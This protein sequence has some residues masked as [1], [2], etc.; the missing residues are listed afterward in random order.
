MEKWYST[1]GY[2]CRRIVGLNKGKKEV[3]MCCHY[4]V[5]TCALS[6]F[7]VLSGDETFAYQMYDKN[8]IV[9]ECV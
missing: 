5:I 1:K 9:V 3:F 4:D 6:V 8:V 7:E 2:K